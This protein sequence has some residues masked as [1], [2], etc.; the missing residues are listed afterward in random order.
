M[1]CYFRMPRPALIK[2]IFKPAHLL[3]TFAKAHVSITA[4]DAVPQACRQ[5][6]AGLASFVARGDNQGD[7]IKAIHKTLTA[8]ANGDFRYLA[9]L[10]K[11]LSQDGGALDIFWSPTSTAP[12]SNDPVILA[13]RDA[14]LALPQLRL[15]M[16]V[17][18]DD[19][20]AAEMIS[21]LAQVA[22]A[23][24]AAGI[25]RYS[26]ER[27]QE[28]RRRSALF[29]QVLIGVYVDLTGKGACFSRPPETSRLPKNPSGPLI[30][31][32]CCF[33]EAFPER[34]PV[35]MV[36]V[37]PAE[38][39]HPSLETLAGWIQGFREASRWNRRRI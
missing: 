1:P 23:S 30:R 34:V 26:V 4:L 20:P 19:A 16:E 2:E 6:N 18:G 12:Q 35:A 25:K 21:F 17:P 29:G 37:M 14:A 8:I 27:E 24:F 10:R 5:M 33:Y 22:A 7:N 13:L 3:E 9:G 36:A 31:F 32:L 11:F 39:R 15:M 38:M 28:G